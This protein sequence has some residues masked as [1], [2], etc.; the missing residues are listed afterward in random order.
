MKIFTDNEKM[1]IS[2]I[3]KNPYARKFIAE[4]INHKILYARIRID[5]WLRKAYI[6]VER[7]YYSGLEETEKKKMNEDVRGIIHTLSF[8][9]SMISFLHEQKIIKTDKPTMND[10]ASLN[11]P[12]FSDTYANIF[13]ITNRSTVKQLIKYADHRIEF[14]QETL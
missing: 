14:M 10:R 1:L 13:E 5:K 7:N 2:E 11:E 8:S 3:K 6:L 12:Q 4:M 9:F